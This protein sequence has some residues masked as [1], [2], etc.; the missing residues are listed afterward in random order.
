[1]S[2]N[3]PTLENVIK[4]EILVL[5]KELTDDPTMPRNVGGVLG[6]PAPGVGTEGYDIF[7]GGHPYANFQMDKWVKQTKCWQSPREAMI[8]RYVWI[9]EQQRSQGPLTRQILVPLW[10]AATIADDILIDNWDC[11]DENPPLCKST[12]EERERLAD[13]RLKR[14]H[15]SLKGVKLKRARKIEDARKRQHKKL[16]LYL[17]QQQQ[18]Q[19]E[20]S[21]MKPKK[22]QFHRQRALKYNEANPANR[23]PI[24]YTHK[25]EA[26]VRYH[27][28][29]YGVPT[30]VNSNNKLPAIR[31]GLDKSSWPLQAG[32]FENTLYLRA[33]PSQRAAW[34]ELYAN[35]NERAGYPDPD[36]QMCSPEIREYLRKYGRECGTFIIPPPNK[37]VSRWM[38]YMEAHDR[39]QLGRRHGQRDGEIEE[40]EISSIKARHYP[41][42]QKTALAQ[43][44]NILP[45]GKQ[46][47]DKDRPLVFP[48]GGLFA[49]MTP[50]EINLM[51]NGV[52]QIMGPRPYSKDIVATAADLIDPKTGMFVTSA[53]EGFRLA[54]IQWSKTKSNTP[55]EA[56]AKRAYLEKTHSYTNP[57]TGKP[58]VLPTQFPGLYL[59]EKGALSSP[60]EEEYA[61][62]IRSQKQ[63]DKLTEEKAWK[64]VDKWEKAGVKCWPNLAIVG[65]GYDPRLVGPGITW[66]EGTAKWYPP[67]PEKKP[68]AP[69]PSEKATTMGKHMTGMKAAGLYQEQQ[70]TA[71][72]S[73]LQWLVPHEC[74][75]CKPRIDPKTG[76]RLYS[77]RLNCICSTYDSNSKQSAAC[78]TTGE[79]VVEWAHEGL[80]LAAWAGTIGVPATLGYE[81]YDQASEQ[82]LSD[83]D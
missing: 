7:G 11:K 73:P 52:N 66:C 32:N 27:A 4:E 78:P 9:I 62:G 57:V 49:G 5:L 15:P 34:S 55:A 80:W 3:K 38:M 13:A 70:R 63:L 41:Q 28:A 59:H 82:I 54:A 75:S 47:F 69:T 42:E 8:D 50:N 79:K 16:A 23:W 6:S 48:Y 46:Q 36:I 14:C 25:E 83:P 81:L 21:K 18:A 10:K 61:L 53:P 76:N 43:R 20:L 65:G 17:N 58:G 37:E 1:M 26:K 56:E 67:S 72:K 71:V 51:A 22:R 30:F 31:E 33:D 24:V 35:L 39:I 60:T 19:N 45:A 12:R 64:I 40:Y 77:D 44:R 2:S 74:V 68:P 29:S